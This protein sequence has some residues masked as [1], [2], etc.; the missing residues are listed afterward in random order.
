MK[1]FIEKFKH[2][3]AESED[4]RQIF[5]EVSAQSLQQFFDQ[6]VYRAGHPELKIEF[7][8]GDFTDS[9]IKVTQTQTLI[10]NIDKPDPFEFPLEI[11]LTFSNETGR[12]TT[13][14][15]FIISGVETII[16]LSK[17]MQSR[18]IEW[19]SIDPQFKILKEIKSVDAPLGMFILQLQNGETIIERIQAARALMN[20]SSAEVILALKKRVIED[21]F[22]GVSV[23]SANTLAT[24]SDS[25]YRNEAYDTLKECLSLIRNP[26]IKSSLISAIGEFRRADSFEIL[27]SVLEDNN[28]SYYVRQ[29]ASI[30]IAWTK[31]EG[32]HSLLENLLNTTSFQELLVQGALVGLTIVALLSTDKP[33]TTIKIRNLLIEKTKPEN[34][35]GVRQSAT[36][37]LSFFIPKVGERLNSVAYGRLKEL[38]DDGWVHVRN[39]ACAVLGTAFKYSNNSNVIDELK[40]VVD[41]DPD[42]QVRRSAFE[43][44]EKIK[45]KKPPEEEVMR[46]MTLQDLKKPPLNLKT[47]EIETMERRIPRK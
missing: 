19:F 37:C 10:D 13:S 20:K 22:W 6:W 28:E 24:F 29:A 5:E 8:A 47:V 2:K 44:I 43:S 33:E 46:M 30:A 42:G 14:E 39:V 3:T 11:K 9:F 18:K 17:K 36:F 23:E 41:N 25:Q 16:P 32:S 26:K 45:A 34:Y 4:L 1:I 27:R 15:E 40:R 12:H 35:H 7:I 38:L 21:T 31:N